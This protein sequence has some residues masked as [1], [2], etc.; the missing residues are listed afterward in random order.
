MHSR[1]GITL[2]LFVGAFAIVLLLAAIFTL[3]YSAITNNPS[4]PAAA[5]IAQP[6]KIVKPP[7]FQTKIEGSDAVIAEVD[8]EG[9]TVKAIYTSSLTDKVEDFS[10]F[11][12]PQEHYGGI[13]YVR[14]LSDDDATPL[15]KIYPLT[16]LTGELGKAIISQPYDS[17][18]LAENQESVLI[19]KGETSTSYG[20][21]N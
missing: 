17:F 4:S 16:I 12:V 11:A 19:I 15:L 21:V 8:K 3:Q 6:A 20:I 18:Q 14:A 1:H 9:N 10:I 13:I 5:N 2:A 7:R